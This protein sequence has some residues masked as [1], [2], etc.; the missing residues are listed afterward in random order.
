MRNLTSCFVFSFFVQPLFNSFLSTES[1]GTHG[2]RSYGRHDRND[3]HAVTACPFWTLPSPI[4]SQT[5]LH[6]PFAPLHPPSRSFNW[7]FSAF[8]KKKNGE[9]PKTETP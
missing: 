3:R 7:L 1:I 5:T 8:G 2:S 4:L 9:A 6:Y